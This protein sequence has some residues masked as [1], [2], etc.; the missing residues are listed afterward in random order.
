MSDILKDFAVKSLGITDEQ[1]AEIVYSDDKVTVK[2]TAL[3]EL[4]N[5]DAERVKTLKAASKDE[6]TD[7]FNKGHQKGLAEGLGKFEQT[8]KEQFGVG[9]SAAQGIDLVKE[10]LV[11]QGQSANIDDEK[12]KLHPLYRKLEVALEKDFVAKADYEKVT[13]DFDGYKSNVEKEKVMH[14]IK[15]DGLKVLRSLK[16]VLPSDPQKALNQELDFL[17]K[18]GAFEYELQIDGSHIIKVDGKRYENA[19]GHP[20]AFAD[21]VKQQSD[22]YFEY[23]VQDQR[24]NAGNSGGNG[25]GGTVTIPK[26]KQAY[27]VALNNESDPKKKIELMHAWNAS[28]NK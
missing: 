21:F 4:L 10:I 2:E 14:V 3:Q 25:G 15:A 28:Q 20:V 11:K 17:D 9:E 8:L 1:F 19:Q 18:L 12:V 23:A 13:Q 6:L 22:K 16:P 24:G 5:R 7:K 26:D 27:M